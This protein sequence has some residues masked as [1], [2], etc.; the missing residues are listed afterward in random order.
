MKKMFFNYVPFLILLTLLLAGCSPRINYTY[1]HSQKFEKKDINC[2]FK[3]YSKLPVNIKYEEIGIVNLVNTT[4]PS[5]LPRDAKSLIEI[6][7]PYVCNSGGDFVV[8][9]V[10]NEGRYMRATV[11]KEIK[12]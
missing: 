1:T 7:R 11:F 6:V 4:N 8:G 3:L 9:D 10:N 2:K 12:E 5:N